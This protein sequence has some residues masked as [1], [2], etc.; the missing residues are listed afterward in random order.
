M[1]TEEKEAL[2]AKIR[3]VFE[4]SQ[5]APLI[6]KTFLRNLEVLLAGASPHIASTE[7]APV[8]GLPRLEELAHLRS[9]GE[10]ALPKVMVCKLNGGLGTGMG[11][12][13]AKSL[14][15]V[16]DG[17]TFLDIAIQQ[18]L[19]ARKQWNAPVPFLCLNSFRTVQ[20]T[21]EV[22][23]NYGDFNNSLLPTS[24]VQHRVPKL[25]VRDYE[26]VLYPRDVTLEWCPPGHG[27]VYSVLVTSG[28][29]SRA[30]A[31][32]MEYLFLSNS[33]NL[34]ATL[35]RELLGYLVQ[36]RAP[37]LMEVTRRTEVDRKGGHLAQDARS[38]QLLLRE[39]AQVSPG[40]EED[41]QD[42]EKYSYFNT[43]SLWINL[44]AL[45][46]SLDK[47]EGVLPLP[48]MKNKKTVDPRDPNSEPVYQLE[49]AMGAALSLFP[50][51]VA[52]EVPRSRFLPVK[53]TADLLRIRS[54]LF[55]LT[56]AHEL[57]HR[58][59]GEPVLVS[60]DST[61]YGTIDAFEERFP[62]GV[63]SLQHA[64]E[65]SVVGDISFGR[66]VKCQGR[67]ELRNETGEQQ[68]IADNTLLSGCVQISK[69][70][71]VVRGNGV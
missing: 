29:L 43:N 41:F 18:I 9:V 59:D 37:F 48:V 15:P 14:L 3:T 22:F 42:F 61:V 70:G 11:L 53:N 28:V 56:P 49:T 12:E 55:E 30:R 4:R 6:E 69:D 24:M 40:D 45:Q 63:P 50:E 20:D 2:Y 36:H 10:A 5:Q 27:D 32:G 25:R 34:G 58:Q 67:V 52:I 8:E 23:E 66:E 65:L 21:E 46:R 33:D 1:R 51:A 57:R 54:D 38:G 35:S 7:I 71:E 13:G 68:H 64:E 17:K 19:T 39:K 62:G 16:R 26:P 44:A 60:L 31:Q 47:H